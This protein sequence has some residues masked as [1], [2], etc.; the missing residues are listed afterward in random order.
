MTWTAR[1]SP[2]KKRTAESE[3]QAMMSDASQTDRIEETV[4][5]LLG[6]LFLGVFGGVVLGVS[7]NIIEISGDRARAGGHVSL[8]RLCY[9][10][11]DLNLHSHVLDDL[12]P[13]IGDPTSTMHS[14]TQR[15]DS[16]AGPERC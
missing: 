6:L 1:P 9:V 15:L 2:R 16:P 11:G 4:F 13:A 3:Q 7:E 14:M 10:V 12:Q 5:L 8:S